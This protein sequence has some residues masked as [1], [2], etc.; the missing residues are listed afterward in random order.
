MF[1]TL[2]FLANSNIFLFTH[3]GFLG[4]VRRV[5]FCYFYWFQNSGYHLYSNSRKS[6]PRTRDSRSTVS[7]TN[8]E[9]KLP[10]V[11]FTK[12][13]DVRRYLRLKEVLRRL[14]IIF[15]P[16]TSDWEEI[17]QTVSFGNN[18]N[19]SPVHQGNNTLYFWL[20]FN[21]MKKN[22]WETLLLF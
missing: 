6:R 7:T 15:L 12:V 19:L 3:S 10:G 1:Y 2:G 17:L 14:V 22:P 20:I 21:R 13:T 11:V 5:K 16:K 8:I 9:F 4:S 18:Q